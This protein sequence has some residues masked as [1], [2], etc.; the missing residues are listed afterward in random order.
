MYKL[1]AFLAIVS[2][3]NAAD[4]DASDT[5][6]TSTA[7]TDACPKD[8]YCLSCN[9]TSCTQCISSYP[10]D[11][12]ICQLPT[13]AVDDCLFY[14]SASACK[15]CDGGFY[16]NSSGACVAI[17]I[18]NCLSVNASAPTIC[19]ICDDKR[20]PDDKGACPSTS[21]CS[22]DN[23]DVCASSTTCSVCSSGYALT[24]STTLTCVKE[25]VTNCA[26]NGTSST[27]CA[28]CEEGYYAATNACTASNAQDDS[29][30]K[31]LSVIVALLAFGKLIA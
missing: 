30:V 29:G 4:T 25:N 19:T 27:T 13:T 15:T 1:V 11:K 23:C 22:L 3:I 16:L 5:N 28:T 2:M 8:E 9:G 14:N 20:L 7:R 31:V 10:D 26:I 6:A 18:D 24:S 12:G 17:K 21:T